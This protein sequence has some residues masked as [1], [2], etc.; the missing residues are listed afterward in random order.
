[1]HKLVNEGNL[2]ALRDATTYASHLLDE[3]HPRYGT[4]LHLAA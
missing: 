4:P 1:M 3:K 2:Q